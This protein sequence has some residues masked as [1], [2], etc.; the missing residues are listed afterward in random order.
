MTTQDALVFMLVGACAAYVGWTLLLPAALRRR[1][2]L[3][4]LRRRLPA[5]LQ[6]RLRKAARQPS[7]CGCNGCDAAPARARSA[8]EQ[9][10]M[11]ATRR[12]R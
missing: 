3:A 12:R 8:A 11:W 10:V 4:L 2:A 1:A 9:P 5:P 6:R 7:G